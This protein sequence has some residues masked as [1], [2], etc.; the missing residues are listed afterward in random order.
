MRYCR[1]V[2]IFY[3]STHAQ[4]LNTRLDH[5]IRRKRQTTTTTVGPAVRA[6][7]LRGARSTCIHVHSKV[8][9]LILMA[10]ED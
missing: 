8:V 3:L 2:L 9:E 6:H 1:S 10:L 4:D 7:F 5:A